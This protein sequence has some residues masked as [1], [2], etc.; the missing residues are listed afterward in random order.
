MPLEIILHSKS[1]DNWVALILPEGHES[2]YNH[3]AQERIKNDIH[4]FFEPKRKFDKGKKKS[5]NTVY[6][7]HA[8]HR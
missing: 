6:E 4:F 1:I 3:E 8:A 2:E 5:E 7:W